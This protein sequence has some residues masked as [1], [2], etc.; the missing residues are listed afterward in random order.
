VIGKA[1]RGHPGGCGELAIKA[2]EPKTTEF[3]DSGQARPQ[4]GGGLSSRLGAAVLSR[5]LSG[6]SLPFAA[7]G[8]QMRSDAQAARAA[9]GARVT[10][11]GRRRLG[12]LRG[13]ERRSGQRRADLRQALRPAP[14]GQEPEVAYPHEP[15]Y[16]LQRIKGFMRSRWLCRVADFGAAPGCRIGSEYSA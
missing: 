4:A 5:T 14:I 13:R 1:E 2:L 15:F 12:R 8:S 3:P 6:S 11:E 16:A 9:L 10:V 7:R